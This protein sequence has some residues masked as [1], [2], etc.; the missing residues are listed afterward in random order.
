MICTRRSI[1]RVK[2]AV[3]ILLLPQQV[4]RKKKLSPSTQKFHQRKN[5]TNT[6]IRTR[7]KKKSNNNN[8]NNNNKRRRNC[9]W[10]VQCFITFFVPS[11][12][13]Y[14]R[15]QRV[16]KI[17]RE[18]LREHSS[19]S[20]NSTI[21]YTLIGEKD[22]GLIQ[23][24]LDSY[25]GNVT[26]TN[27]TT[28]TTTN[29]T[30]TTTSSSSSTPSCRQIAKLDKGEEVDTLQALWEFCNTSNGNDNN[31][32]NNNND[33]DDTLVS[34][35]H[36]KGSFHYTK[37]NEMARLIGT[38][39]ALLCREEMVQSPATCNICTGIFNLFPQY[40]AG[41]N[42]WT[43]KC[44]YIKQLMQPNKYG[45]S[46]QNMYDNSL[47]NTL[48]V[49]GTEYKC[50]RKKDQAPN[51]LGLGRYAMER[52]VLSHPNVQPCDISPK[53]IKEVKYSPRN[54]KPRL[55]LSRVPR[56]GPKFH[57]MQYR[58]TSY[59]RV[60][61]RLFEW[62]YLYGK[63][64]KNDSWVW[65]FYKDFEHGAKEFMEQCYNESSI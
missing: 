52:W 21:Y 30:T 26:A 23:Q 50:L 2:V 57:G 51:A 60:E 25:C 59:E 48:I 62:H 11:G 3:A 54:W 64:P 16:K 20:P 4:L 22:G 10:R 44:S 61:G 1:N 58:K 32:H 31:N 42:M 65:K 37:S 5:Q 55:P 9:Y 13:P 28:T 46:L 56:G 17:V 63:V 8:N 39:S 40:H 47:S 34:Y 15:I 19:T 24:T 49:N 29:T 35:I 36:D 45:R 18:Q 41:S 33:D 12:V 7:M 14:R 6:L 43:A 38:R 27:T 53:N